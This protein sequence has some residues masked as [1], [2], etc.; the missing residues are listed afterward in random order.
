[1]SRRNPR[2]KPPRSKRALINERKAKEKAHRRLMAAHAQLAKSGGVIS[3]H[4]PHMPALFFDVRQA[5]G[6][7]LNAFR[8]D[9]AGCGHIEGTNLVCAK[10][11]AIRMPTS[12]A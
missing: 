5:I 1:M 9:T 4:R 7:A 8:V 2:G 6:R 11:Q 3:K 10:C 12:K